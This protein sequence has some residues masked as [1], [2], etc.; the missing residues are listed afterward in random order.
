MGNPDERCFECKLYSGAGSRL[1]VRSRIFAH[2]EILSGTTTT[3]FC[4]HPH[5]LGV[6]A[7]ISYTPPNMRWGKVL[8]QMYII[9]EPKPKHRENLQT[10]ETEESLEAENSRKDKPTYIGEFPTL[11]VDKYL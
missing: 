10:G 6:N 9:G 3:D 4:N 8:P 11:R 1:I 7:F 2:R 5:A